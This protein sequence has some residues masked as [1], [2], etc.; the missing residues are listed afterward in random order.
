MVIVKPISLVKILGHPSEETART[1]GAKEI[2]V[3]QGTLQKYSVDS[4]LTNEHVDAFG[5]ISVEPDYKEQI[6]RL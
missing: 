1:N 6:K 4:G 2:D 5:G 3:V